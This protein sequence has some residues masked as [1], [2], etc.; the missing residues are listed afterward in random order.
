METVSIRNMQFQPGR[1]CCTVPEIAPPVALHLD[2]FGRAVYINNH[3]R[4]Y[5]CCW[6]LAHCRWRWYIRLQPIIKF[7][8]KKQFINLFR[9]QLIPAVDSVWKLTRASSRLWP[10]LLLRRTLFLL[11]LGIFSIRL[12]PN[13]MWL[14]KQHK[15]LSTF[16]NRRNY[17]WTDSFSQ[18]K[19]QLNDMQKGYWNSRRNEK[20]VR[21]K[22]NSEHVH[23]RFWRS[24][25]IW[26]Q[27][28]D[29]CSVWWRTNTFG[30]FFGQT[31][32]DKSPFGQTLIVE[33]EYEDS[34]YFSTDEKETIYNVMRLIIAEY[35][36]G[37]SKC[38]Y[39]WL[40]RVF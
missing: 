18:R 10:A 22:D 21:R 15:E 39:A 3:R 7:G 11:L 2:M 1:R 25:K 6:L 24:K 29:K 35:T 20:H 4:N 31:K 5:N 30:D 34:V 28:F 19:S 38:P 12:I 26:F 23:Y 32:N 36:K 13:V 27:K 16:W 37:R 9:L 40:M 8:T 14:N 33:R 17:G